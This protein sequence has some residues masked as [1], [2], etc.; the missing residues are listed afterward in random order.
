MANGDN[1]LSLFKKIFLNPDPIEKDKYFKAME[2]T[3][4]GLPK[5]LMP[6]ETK[7]VSIPSETPFTGKGLPNEL[8]PPP[9]P[10]EDLS[11]M[12]T[13]LQPQSEAQGIPFWQH[14]L[15]GLA[16]GAKPYLQHL[17]AG[18]LERGRKPEIPDWMQRMEYAEQLR[19]TRPEKPL[20]KLQSL[21][22]SKTKADIKGHKNKLRRGLFANYT[23]FEA[24]GDYDTARRR[25]ESERPYVGE[26]GIDADKLWSEI[27]SEWNI[28]GPKSGILGILGRKQH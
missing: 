18:E 5:T 15:Y 10:Q 2:R 28:R 6:L 12:P 11:D 16:F 17:A 24:Q 9:T 27:K 3:P 21:Q 8:T 25:F 23:N 26:E 19:Q 1:E 22:V 4:L 14:I 7:P 20:T 13:I